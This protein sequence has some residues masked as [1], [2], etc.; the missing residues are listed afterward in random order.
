MDEIKYKNETIR[1]SETD[2]CW[3]W[4]GLE[5]KSLKSIKAAIDKFQ[6]VKFDQIKAY[7]SNGNYQDES[8][9]EV[10]VTSKAGDRGYWIK[11]SKGDRRK[12]NASRLF[13]FTDRNKNLVELI[14]ENRK[15]ANKLDDEYSDLS[16]NLEK[17]SAPSGE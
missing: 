12:E 16:D 13:A 2:D 8:Y 6:N 3:T 4:E 5:D 14:N 17:F 1:F 9:S 15:A 10:M 11:N 7:L